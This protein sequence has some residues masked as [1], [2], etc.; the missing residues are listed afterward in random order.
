MV[1]ASPPQQPA[2]SRWKAAVAGTLVLALALAGAIYLLVDRFGGDAPPT[3]G[4]TP[5]PATS[6]G[7]STPGSG[8][9]LDELG[10]LLDE[11]DGEFDPVLLECLAPSAGATPGA[12]PDAD[13]EAQVEAIEAIVAAERGLPA[14]DDLSIEFVTPEEVQRR[15]VEIN[16]DELD[17]EEAAV[18]T[19]IL[20]AL[21]AVEPGT[22]LVQA[23]LDALEAGVGGFYDL[24]TGELVIGS[25]SMDA[26]G[27]FITAH[28]LV[29]AMA[30]ASLGL[31]DLDAIAEE[32]GSD[33]AYAALS[34]VEGDATLYSQ[35][36]VGDH[37]PLSQLLELEAMSAE[38][39]DALAGMPHFVT[40]NLEFPYLEGMTFTCHTYL[41]GGW[42]A[43]DDTYENPPATTAQVLFPERYQSGE[44]AVDVRAPS[45]P[46]GWEMLDSDTFGAADLLFLLEDA[47]LSD[48]LDRVA[49]W[50]G[51]EVTVWANGEDR[52]VAL[53]LA[54]RGGTHPL[55][56]TVADYY[57]AAFPDAS[58]SATGDGATFEAGSQSATVSCAGDEVALG[59]GPDLPTSGA[60]IG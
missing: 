57:E 22:D 6:E 54:D 2:R 41:D 27:T 17:A 55:C 38:T 49:A 20:A 12:V 19:D 26:M 13:I 15:A 23:Q 48:P 43:V 35:Q 34:A 18:A 9:L 42:S 14:G 4:G 28:E 16:E 39:E 10:D 29:H 47:E 59:V 25:E 30:D 51:G 33:A 1:D 60:A 31:P 24:R 44:K 32:E 53:V 45:G 46:G 58:R 8:G 52:A 21:G 5:A 7:G 11:L 40:R 3:A 36:F 50:A 37:L 56:D